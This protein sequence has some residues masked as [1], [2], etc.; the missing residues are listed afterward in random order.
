VV[1]GLSPRKLSDL[2]N[3]LRSI[4]TELEAKPAAMITDAGD[5][6]AQD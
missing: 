4:V 3:S 1:A 6:S 2:T 5:L